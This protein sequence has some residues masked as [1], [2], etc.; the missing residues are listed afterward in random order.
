MMLMMMMM[1]MMTMM[2]AMTITMT[3]VMMMRR[4]K[5][6]RIETIFDDLTQ[7]VKTKMLNVTPKG[8]I[9]RCGH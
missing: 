5:R 3:M 2:M 7:M 1:M 9:M 8:L 4:K 6:R